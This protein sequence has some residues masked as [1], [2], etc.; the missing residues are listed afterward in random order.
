MDLRV[1]FFGISADLTEQQQI[2][3]S[4]KNNLSLNELKLILKEKYPK[5]KNLSS[6]AI[7][8][9]E[10]YVNYDIFLKPNDVIAIIPPVSG[11]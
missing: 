11:G 4:V 6:Y 5:L 2:L 9:N 8:V 1:L 10:E 3:L 7:A